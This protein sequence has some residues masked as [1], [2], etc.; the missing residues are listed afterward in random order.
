MSGKTVI[1]ILTI[2]IASVLLLLNCQ[3]YIE[4]TSHGNILIN[5][6]KTIPLT[7][8]INGW[9][10]SEIRDALN[11][12]NIRYEVVIECRG[13]KIASA[14]LKNSESYSITVP[15]GIKLTA[16]V[17]LYF[18][19]PDSNSEAINAYFASDTKDGVIVMP[20]QT[21]YLDFTIDLDKP[22]PVT[23]YA[24]HEELAGNAPGISDITGI[25]TYPNS[26]TL[27][28]TYKSL[29]SGAFHLVS[30]DSSFNNINS[31]NNPEGR[32]FKIEDPESYNGYGLWYLDKENNRIRFENGDNPSSI[33]S[34][35]FSDRNLPS[36]DINYLNL[37]NK[38]DRVVSVVYGGDYYFFLL[39]DKG[40]LSIL[41]ESAEWGQL[42]KIDFATLSSIYPD[43]PFILD[44]EKDPDGDTF[45]ASKIGLFLID[46][47]ALSL[48]ANEEYH[49]ALNRLK[50]IIRITDPFD[51]RKSILVT[52][53]KVSGNE[54]F[55]GTR[56]G[57]YKIDKNSS[58][59]TSFAARDP[60][61]GYV[62]LDQSAIKKVKEVGNA[63]VTDLYTN[64][65]GIILIVSTT[66]SLIFVNRLNGKIRKFT[67][68]DGLPFIPARKLAHTPSYSKTDYF[69][70]G[71]SPIR[72]VVYSS[73]KYWIATMHG[74][75]SID[76][77]KIF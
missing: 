52:S 21:V 39:Y 16:F 65:E 41:N 7:R 19:E 77:N 46:K 61:A 43:L 54:I 8:A 36:R 32:L 64:D 56:Y 18:T 68:W 28:L 40:M 20:N 17:G 71:I 62:Y 27:I 29:I 35:I 13:K 66:D 31:Q 37:I 75:A 50:K 42:A 76:E 2:L 30:Y 49:K 10:S 44:I 3:N 4:D 58:S 51:N 5:T 47:V 24:Y 11:S 73:N 45:F 6:P 74:L 67:V 48:F 38:I 26:S 15:A 57:L 25:A 9:S 53:V 34:I 14:I 33:G 1:F 69:I 63:K 12:D 59:W 22:T 60:A 70:H 72:Q 23:Y 55:L